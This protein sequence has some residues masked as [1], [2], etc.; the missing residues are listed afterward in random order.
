L[1]NPG[2]MGNGAA[3]VS[4]PWPS[5]GIQAIIMAAIVRVIMPV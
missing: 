5:M 4:W 3:M 2:N 1:D